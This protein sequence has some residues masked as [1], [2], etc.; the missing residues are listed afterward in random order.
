MDP[1]LNGRRPEQVV[2]LQETRARVVPKQLLPFAF[3]ALRFNGHF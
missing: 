1:R 2:S 3:E